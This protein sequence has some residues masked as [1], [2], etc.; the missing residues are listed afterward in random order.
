MGHNWDGTMPDRQKRI[1]VRS[2]HW[3]DYLYVRGTGHQ[4]VNCELSL[5]CKKDGCIWHRD[6]LDDVVGMREIINM[7]LSHWREKHD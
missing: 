4:N 7:Y 5:M 6:I 2:N 3:A 1:P